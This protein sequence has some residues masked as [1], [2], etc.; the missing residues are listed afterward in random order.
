MIHQVAHKSTY[1]IKLFITCNNIESSIRH[2]ALPSIQYPPLFDGILL[3]ILV[4][5]G[6]SNVMIGLKEA[7]NSVST[8]PRPHRTSHQV[9]GA[10][11]HILAMLILYEH[12][13]HDHTCIHDVL[14][15]LLT[16]KPRRSSHNSKLGLQNLKCSL[17]IFPHR[18]LS[19]MEI[20]FLLTFGGS[21]LHECHPT[22]DKSHP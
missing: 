19:I 2:C 22:W 13:M 8:S 11:D 3:K 14:K 5:I 21:Q 15:D 10:I 9:I 17:Y 4:H 12:V 16:P 18:R 7:R 1:N 6:V 20:N